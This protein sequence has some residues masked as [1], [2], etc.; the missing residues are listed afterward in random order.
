MARV[1]EQG[2]AMVGI[3]LRTLEALAHARDVPGLQR[4]VKMLT[5]DQQHFLIRSADDSCHEPAS[6][7]V[8]DGPIPRVLY[9]RVGMKAFSEVRPVLLGVQ[10]SAEF[11]VVDNSG[12]CLE[13]MC[14]RQGDV[15]QV[16]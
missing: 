6:A 12:K 13:C 8:Y 5:P 7:V 16:E 9:R 14:T 1:D 4:A 11:R 2:S 3:M 10:G 15:F